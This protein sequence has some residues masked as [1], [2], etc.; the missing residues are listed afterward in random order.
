M[1]EDESWEVVDSTYVIDSKHLRLRKDSI[2]LPS[3]ERIEDYY[4]RESRGYSVVFAVT[5]D[6]RV[7]L[8]REY[9]HG[10]GAGVLGLP[11][12]SLDADETAAACAR[13]ELEEETGYIGDPQTPE[14]IA[15]FL[16]E[17]TNSDGRFFLFL[18]RNAR[19]IGTPAPDPTEHIVVEYATFDE[20]HRYVRDGI[21]DVSPHVTAIY[22]VLDRL[23]KLNPS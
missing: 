5:P 4:V 23:G 17:P 7:V 21:I 2:V 11:A 10:I 8:V 1:K 16:S 19:P 13:R 6:D 22:F 3:G 9:K 14:H 20:L 15:T 18:A 12:G